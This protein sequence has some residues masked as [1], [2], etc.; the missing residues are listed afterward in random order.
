MFGLGFSEVLVILV[1]ALLVLGPEKLPGVAKSI[2]KTLGQLQR[3]LDEFKRE[4]IFPRLD[5][6]VL[7]TPPREIVRQGP[8]G[9]VCESRPDALPP[10]TEPAEQ[11]GAAPETTSRKDSPTE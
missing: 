10:V 6:D 9:D 11:A 4:L 5:D 8:R 7:P 3:G 1:V 2:G